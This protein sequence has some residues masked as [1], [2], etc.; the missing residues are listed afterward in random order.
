MKRVRRGVERVRAARDF[1]VAAVARARSDDSSA[2]LSDEDV[3]IPVRIATRPMAL[4][5]IG[6]RIVVS[7]FQFGLRL[8][9]DEATGCSGATGFR[10]AHVQ[11][12]AAS[13]QTLLDHIEYA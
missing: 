12:H 1:V 8:G 3:L 2:V 10:I 13:R 7:V 5:S 9:V 4:V 11:R 6:S